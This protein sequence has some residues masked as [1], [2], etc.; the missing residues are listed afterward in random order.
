MGIKKVIKRILLFE[1]PRTVSAES[2]KRTRPTAQP[3]LGLAYLAAIL[4][5]E[6]FEVMIVDAIIEDPLCSSGK[7]TREGLLRFGLGDDQIAKIIE[8]YAPDMV[9]VS[10]LVSAKYNDAKNICSITKRVDPDCVTVMGGAHPT[11]MAKDVLKNADLDYVVLGEGDYS[12]L[13]LIR[14]IEG[15]LAIS[16][17]DGVAMKE[18]GRIRII[19]KTRYIKDLDDIPFPAR[20]LLKIEDYWKVNLPHGE[21]TRVPWSTIMTSRG[22]PAS[23]I[24]C[25]VQLVWGKK[26]RARSAENVLAEIDLLINRYGIKELLIEDDNFTFDKKRTEKILDGIIDRG[27]DIT[28]TTPSGIAIFA[29]DANLLRKIKRSGCTSITLAIESGSQRVLNEV[30]KKP[31]QLK[32]V[33]EIAREAKKVG[34][35]TKAFFMLGIPGETK[36]E[37]RQTLELARRLKL[38]W[39]CF[40]ITT[41]L[42]GTALYD[43]C[44]TN[45]YIEGDIDPVNVEYTT[46][47]IKTR[48]FDDKYV[49]ELWEEA[50]NINFLENPNL[51]DGGNVDQAIRD[52]TRVIRMVPSHEM[53]H[54]ALGVAYE[55]KMMIE[56]AVREFRSVMAI[57]K[58]NGTARDR[59]KKYESG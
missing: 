39:S 30:V 54:L 48:E 44:K 14:Y 57:N 23:C 18:G 27:W 46:A 36:E 25:A 42:P 20:H 1:P 11:L 37:M 35:K 47:R 26:Y 22:C 41:P 45:N 31:L 59:I 6:G 32:K 2:L 4:E 17:L 53:A 43:I 58:D 50:N 52:F 13:E 33:E 55:K 12:F 9:G 15:K 28:W 16:E 34:L 56:E 40:S 3:P 10:C 24:Y 7:I 21:A 8:E 49:N 38:D 19:P 5:R 51:E 29:L